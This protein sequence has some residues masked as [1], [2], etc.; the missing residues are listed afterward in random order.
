MARSMRMP[1]IPEESVIQN[2]LPPKPK[3]L[4]NGKK[5]YFLFTGAIAEWLYRRVQPNSKLGF[6]IGWSIL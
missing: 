1:E 4:G 6:R 2:K 3:C 5:H